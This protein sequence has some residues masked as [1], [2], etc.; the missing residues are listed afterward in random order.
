MGADLPAEDLHP[1][2][3]GEQARMRKRQ[4]HP[5]RLGMPG[6]AEGGNTAFDSEVHL[7]DAE[8]GVEH[9]KQVIRAAHAAST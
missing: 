6:L 4:R 3:P 8:L 5:E 7:D 1:F 2:G 9:V